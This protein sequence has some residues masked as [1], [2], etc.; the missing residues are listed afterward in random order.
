MLNTLYDIH[1]ACIIQ[2]QATEYLGKSSD[3]DL[4]YIKDL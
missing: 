1:V 3:I 2:I 4:L